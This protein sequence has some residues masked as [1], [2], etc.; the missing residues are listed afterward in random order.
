MRCRCNYC[1]ACRG[2]EG[3]SESDRSLGRKEG[4]GKK[5]NT[6]K[7]T[8]KRGR[9]TKR[10]VVTRRRENLKG[11]R[12]EKTNE[13]RQR[14]YEKRRTAQK[15]TIEWNGGFATRKGRTRNTLNVRKGTAYD[16]R[17]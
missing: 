12:E 16:R 4:K 17:E 10:N 13:G 8:Q 15:I 5:R 2:L 6:T 11:W 3:E 7:I 9:E 1:Y 14:N